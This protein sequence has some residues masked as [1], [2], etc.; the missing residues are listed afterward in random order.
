MGE[1]IDKKYFSDEY[2]GEYSTEELGRKQTAATKKKIAKAMTGK[3]NSQ[4]K[5]GRRSY[6]NVVKAKKGQHVHHKNGDSKDNRPGNLEKFPEKGPGR[7]KHEKKHKRYKN[8]SSSGGR[9]TPRRGYTAK[10]K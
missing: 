1:N 8:F 2:L 5:D 4:Y 7:A 3:G 10:R 9:K 6:R